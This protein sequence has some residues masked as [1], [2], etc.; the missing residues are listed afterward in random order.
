MVS[1]AFV[2]FAVPVV[3]SVGAFVAAVRASVATVEVAAVVC[4]ECPV[5]SGHQRRAVVLSA[6]P[7]DASARRAAAPGLAAG[8]A[9]QAVAGVSARAR[10]WRVPR[11]ES[12]MK[13]GG[14]D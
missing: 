12:S 9:D 3:V 7:A 1:L 6:A 10:D 4:A 14:L 13:E 5:A 2:V 8:G 11:S